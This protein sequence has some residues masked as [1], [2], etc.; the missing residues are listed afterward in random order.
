MKCEVEKNCLVSFVTLQDPEKYCH[1]IKLKPEKYFLPGIFYL[2]LSALPG[3]LKH[4]FT[5]M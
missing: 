1:L 2:G 5:T 3:G 4:S